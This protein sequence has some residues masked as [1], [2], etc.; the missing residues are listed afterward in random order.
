MLIFVKDYPA[1]LYKERDNKILIIAD[2][3]LGWELSLAKNGIHIPSQM[4][5][6]REKI[7]QLIDMTTPN[8]LIILG[9][10]KHTIAKPKPSEWQDIPEFFN[11]LKK[12]VNNIQIIKGNHDGNLKPLLP[13][14][15]QLH[16]STG[17]VIGN[18]GLIHGHANP[19][20]R[21]LN[22][23]TLIMGHVHPMVTFRDRFRFRIS[24][25]VWVKTE[26]NPERL[27]TT[28]IKSEKVKRVKN[29]SASRARARTLKKHKLFIMPCFNE[30]LGGRSINSYTRSYNIGP[31]LRHIDLDRSEV[32]MLDGTYLG[33]LQQLKTRTRARTYNDESC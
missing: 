15:L 22:C 4:P 27:K 1:I 21:L 25:Q 6:I 28:T 9:D 20:E 33:R 13:Q 29:Q 23:S 14:K 11:S 18:L 5:K 8:T 16:P 7:L 12:K 26:Y 24:T 3:H 2:L 31:I 10:V 19:A 32:N 17:L 30:F